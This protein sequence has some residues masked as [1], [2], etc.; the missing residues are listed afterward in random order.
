M[1]ELASSASVAQTAP[2]A[3]AM[4]SVDAASIAERLNLEDTA[5]PLAAAAIEESLAA[6]GLAERDDD[7]G[8]RMTRRGWQLAGLAFG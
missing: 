6:S 1:A 8:L 2:S 7:G 5:G 3:S 4:P